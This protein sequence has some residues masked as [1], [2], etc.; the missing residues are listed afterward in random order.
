MAVEEE[1]RQA[2]VREVI[3]IADIVGWLRDVENRHRD[4]RRRRGLGT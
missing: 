4:R 1:V 3:A 2:P